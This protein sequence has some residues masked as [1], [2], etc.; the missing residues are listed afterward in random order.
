MSLVIYFCCSLYLSFYLCLPTCLPIN[1][2]LCIYVSTYQLISF[3]TGSKIRTFRL[4]QGTSHRCSKECGCL[5]DYHRNIPLL[6][7]M[8]FLFPFFFSFHVGFKG[9]FDLEGRFYTQI[10]IQHLLT[11]ITLNNFPT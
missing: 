2:Y 6:R 9:N 1:L 11:A 5:Q 4:A 3:Y 7:K 10:Y 8:W